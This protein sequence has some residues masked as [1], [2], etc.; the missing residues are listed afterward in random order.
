M[1]Q[2][3]LMFAR[4]IAGMI[5]ASTTRRFRMR[6]AGSAGRPRPLRRPPGPSAQSAGMELGGYGRADVARHCGVRPH[7]LF[8]QQGDALHVAGDF[9]LMRDLP[10]EAYA[11]DQPAEVLRVGG[12]VELDYRLDVRVRA[13]ERQPAAACAAVPAHG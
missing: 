3:R 4:G 8:R 7:R 5:D 13:H 6:G 12:E 11:C 1:M 10:G 2:V 9:R